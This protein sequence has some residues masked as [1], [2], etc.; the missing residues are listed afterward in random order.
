MSNKFDVVVIGAGAAGLMCAAEAGRR[1][2]KVLVLDH[3]K[4]PGRKILISGG[5]R[6][7]F[8]NNEVSAKNY[9]CRNPHFVK[10]ALSQYSNWD[11]ISMIYK[12]GI[13][14]EERDHGQLFC[15]D[16]AKEIV[17]MLLSECD[18]PNIA[19]RYQVQL[20][21][22]EK[23]EQGFVLRAGAEAFECQSLVVAT[24]GLS[25]PKLGATPFGYKIAEQFG[26]PVVPTTAGLVPFTLHKQD[27]EDFAELSGIAIPAEITAEDGT[28]FKEALLFTHR[29]LSGPAVLQISSYWKAGQAVSI[30]LVPEVDVLELLQRNLE[31]H[32]NQSMKNTLAKVLPKRLIEVLI[33]RNELTD[34]PLKQYN[35]K[36]LQEIVEYLEHWKIAPNGTEGYRTA[37]VTLGG[38]DT[39]YLSSKTMECKTVPGLY[40]IGEVMDVTGWLGGYNFQWCWS[41]GF[42]AGQWV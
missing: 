38:V 15:L 13:E 5:G 41:S 6:C 9:L 17:N 8:T 23:T 42:V 19:Q 34:K 26:I 29:G 20:T 1:G 11:F 27:K 21:E 24:G 37:E 28:L 30:N 2:R 7:N 16:S 32:P 18:Q 33:E 40:F 36:E 12:Y 3:A 22:I 4:K 14:F 39:D 35:G 25:M 31:K 10:S